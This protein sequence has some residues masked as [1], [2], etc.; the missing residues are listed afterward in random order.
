M[1]EDLEKLANK[2]NKIRKYAG[3][4]LAFFIFS[5]QS[6]WSQVISNGNVDKID[7]SSPKEYEIG[8]IIVTGVKY[9]DQD[10]L[11]NISELQVGQTIKVPGDQI[12]KAIEKLWK[13][14][15]FSDVQIK[16]SKI[17][18]NRIFLEIALQ[19]RPRLSKFGIQGVKKSEADD[20]RDII[21]LVRGNQITDN[22]LANTKLSVKNYFI[23]KGFYNVDVE[24]TQKPDS[25]FVNSVILFIK[26]KPNKRVKIKNIRFHGNTD[27]ETYKA[28]LEEQNAGF[29]KVHFKNSPFNDS[30]LRR[31]LKETK[32]KTWYNIFKTSKY[33]ESNFKEDKKK[34]LEKYNERGYRDARILKDSLSVNPDGTLNLDIF[35]EEGQKYYF[36]N[37]TWVGNTKY[38]SEFLSRYLGINK[39]DIFNQ[40]LLDEKLFVSEISLSS[41]YLDDGYLFFNL[42]PVEIAVENDSID[43]EMRMQEGKQARINRVTV[44]GNTKT[45]DHVI[46]REIRT[47]PGDLFSRSDIIRTQR[48]L[49]QLGYFDPEKLNVTPKPDP[50]TSTVDLEY[51]VEEKPSDQIELSGGWGANMIVGTLGLTFN[52]FSTRN[53]F[54]KS[55]WSPLPTGDGQKLSLR[56]QTNGIYYQSYSATFIEPWL[57]GKK[58]NSL[59]VSVYHNIMS[60]GYAKTSDYYGTMK[61]TGASVGIGRR[62]KWPDDFFT[63]Y[64]EI[65]YQI[66]D[67]NNYNSS[68]FSFPFSSGQSNSISFKTI[69]TRSSTDQPIYPRRGSVFSVSLQLTPPWSLM[70]DKDYTTISD[71]ERYKWI[72]YHKWKLSG[73][74]FTNIVD[75]LV[76]VANA[77]FGF[78]GMYNTAYGVSPFEGFTMGGD[79]L[80]SYNL[81]GKETIALRGY[82]NSSITPTDGGNIYDKFVLEM[83]Y[84]ISLDPSATLYG[85]VFV[86]GGNSWSSGS[87]FSPFN[88]YRSAGVGVRVFLPMFGKLGV[89]WGY[90]Y[91]PVKGRPTANGS[92]FHFIIGQSF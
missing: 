61:I 3:L 46:I 88:I 39:G 24:I 66:Y 80:M 81:Y 89:D 43:I 19:E 20:I 9:L 30:K 41:L 14:G 71:V 7:Y 51:I 32:Q 10:V 78:L 70:N 76:L 49:A 13:Q 63:L 8:G 64:N 82:E 36:R 86:E 52:N 16:A 91:D 45:N 34:V 40:T 60:T 58:P 23:D 65:A 69:L 92:Q 31:K 55:A 85:L 27:N 84:P 38:S 54:N 26:V 17:I 57:G 25:N 1:K 11:I 18:E 72:E 90:G 22:I 37:I 21:H 67:L 33:V 79:G 15:L 4:V 59:S 68:Y 75:K 47:K 29:W 56:A 28:M 44:V 77:E 5:N 87:R 73:Q 42:T 12:T 48:E 53:I 6:L 50:A 74:W 83:R 35:I 2:Y 62:L